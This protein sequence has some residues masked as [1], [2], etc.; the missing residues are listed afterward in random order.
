MVAIADCESEFRQYDYDTTL[1]RGGGGGMVGIF[2]ISEA[3]HRSVAEAKGL[4]IGT[5]DGNIMYARYL[6]EEDGIYPWMSSFQCWNAK[7][8]TSSTT[9]TSTSLQNVSATNPLLTRDLQLG[10]V[11][12]ELLA[13]QQILNRNGFI[14]ALDGPGSPGNETT[15]YGIRTRNAVRSFQCAKQNICKGNELSTGYGFVNQET[16]TA[17]LALSNSVSSSSTVGT[18]TAEEEKAKLI[19]ELQIKIALLTEQI[20]I[21]IEQQK[22]E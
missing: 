5:I 17:L 7:V 21:L 10:V 20:R 18:L 12:P 1:L 14:L 6:Y 22:G 19:K 4:D 15:M 3:V 9:A 2:Q 13:L 11:N 16:R 8:K